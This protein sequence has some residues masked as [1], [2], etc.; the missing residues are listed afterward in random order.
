M[1]RLTLTPLVDAVVLSCE[2]GYAK[3]DREIHEESLQRLHAH[4]SNTTL[5]GRTRVCPGQTD[6]HETRLLIICGS[7]VSDHAPTGASP[8]ADAQGYPDLAQ[9]TRTGP[10]AAGMRVLFLVQEGVARSETWRPQGG[11]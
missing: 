10:A 6:D 2:V 5:P 1:D 7:L 3:P 9:R 4:R 11:W 8:Q